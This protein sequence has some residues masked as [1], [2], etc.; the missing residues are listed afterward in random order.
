MPNACS[1]S[2]ASPFRA[3]LFKA[4]FFKTCLRKFHEGT[5]PVRQ[6]FAARRQSVFLLARHFAKGPR[7][8][9]RQEH[10]IV[11]KALAATRRPDQDAVDARLEFFRMA[12]RPGNT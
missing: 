9:V 7:V 5:G 4:S 11:A 1:L 8:P 10:R 2:E 6:T 12:V 3:S